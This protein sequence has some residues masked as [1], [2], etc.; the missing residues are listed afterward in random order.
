[1]LDSS[2]TINP[3]FL[4]HFLGLRH[5][6]ILQNKVSKDQK[7]GQTVHF[8]GRE[9]CARCE[10]SGFLIKCVCGT[11]T[12]YISLRYMAICIEEY[13]RCSNVHTP[14]KDAYRVESK[15]VEVRTRPL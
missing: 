8:A 10:C 3:L 6:V 9:G 14:F 13:T 5:R 12:G 1:M 2:T 7:Q 4:F 11:Y 15:P